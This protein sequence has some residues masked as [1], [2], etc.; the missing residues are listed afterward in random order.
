MTTFTPFERELLKRV[1]RTNDL[2]EYLLM[3]FAPRKITL[4]MGQQT[5]DGP[6]TTPAE[7]VA[8]K[9]L[10]AS[11]LRPMSRPPG[12]PPTPEERQARWEARAK[13]VGLSDEKAAEVIGRVHTDL[14]NLVQPPAA[15]G[16]GRAMAEAEQRR[17]ERDGHAPRK[18]GAKKATS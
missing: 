17:A 15:A 1:D 3:A 5:I 16:Q 6:E 9:L 18:R 11:G 8:A 2:L 12:T 7:E 4:G 10:E 13:E 14:D